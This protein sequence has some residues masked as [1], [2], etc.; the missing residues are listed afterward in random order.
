MKSVSSRL[1]V[2]LC[3]Y[4]L[5]NGFRIATA[6]DLDTIT[7]VGR[8]LDQNGAVIPGAT[9]QATHYR[10]SAARVANTDAEG[11][12]KLMQLEPGDYIVRVS[13]NGFATTETDL[14]KTSA[15][16]TVSIDITLKVS[17]INAET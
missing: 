12:Y 13:S 6:Q 11:R 5:L 8:V 9:V 3:L 10:T 4:F 2:Y 7:L 17:T 16:Q 1:F 15:G 14:F